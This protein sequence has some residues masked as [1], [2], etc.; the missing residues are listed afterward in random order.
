MN[1]YTAR[2]NKVQRDG[3]NGGEFGITTAAKYNRYAKQREA[4]RLAAQ[5][6]EANRAW[7]VEHGY[8]P[9]DADLMFA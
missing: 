7:M 8:N 4:A 9:D 1:K 2:T 5:Q 6:N 3:R